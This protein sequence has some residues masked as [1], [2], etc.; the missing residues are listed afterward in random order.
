MQIRFLAPLFALSL[1]GVLPSKAVVAEPFDWS[2]FFAGGYG[3]YNWGDLK[4]TKEHRA[5]T[6]NFDENLW[7]AGVFGGYRWQMENG[8]VLGAELMVPFYQEKGTAVDNTFFPAPQYNPPVKYEAKGNWGVFLKG[9]VGMAVDHTLPFAE[10]G[11]G[12]VNATGKTLNVDVNDVYTPGATQK[13]TNTHLALLIGAGIDHAVSD[14][15][16]V[17]IRYNYVHLS[18]EN[19]EMPWNSPPPNRFGASAHK[20]IVTVAYKF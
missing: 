3:A 2:G 19:Y 14:H 4:I 18:K 6:G 20:V 9:Q 8:L 5:T 13:D 11:I 7:E 1:L 16:V 10:F 12:A 15:F 17:G